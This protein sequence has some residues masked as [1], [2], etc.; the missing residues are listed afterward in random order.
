[1]LEVYFLCS[2]F[3]ILKKSTVKYTWFI[4]ESI[5]NSLRLSTLI[6]RLTLI[7]IKLILSTIVDFLLL[8]LKLILVFS[9]LLTSFCHK[10]G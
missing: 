9:I 3:Y 10:A 1:M 4:L 6:L 7:L 5:K 8:I 2:I